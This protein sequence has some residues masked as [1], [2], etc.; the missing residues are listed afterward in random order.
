VLVGG[1]KIR[2]GRAVCGSSGKMGS[3]S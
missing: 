3:K 2:E 1:L